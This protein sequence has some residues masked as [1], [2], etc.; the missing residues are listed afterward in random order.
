VPN[1][2]GVWRGWY[3]YVLTPDGIAEVAHVAARRGEYHTV[4]TNLIEDACTHHLLAV[5]GRLDPRHARE[6]TEAAELAADG[7]WIIA[8]SRRAEIIAA[9][10]QQDCQLSRLDGEWWL[11]F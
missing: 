1:D 6:W 4:L 11:N 7:P 8:H 3:A 10:H 5:R 9:F 2:K